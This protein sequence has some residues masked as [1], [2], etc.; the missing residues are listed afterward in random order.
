M[1]KVIH[2]AQSRDI[3]ED[4]FLSEFGCRCLTP[5]RPGN[6]VRDPV[7]LLFG[8]GF[9]RSRRVVKVAGFFVRLARVRDE[10]RGES[11]GQSAHGTNIYIV[12]SMLTILSRTFTFSGAFTYARIEF[13]RKNY[14]EIHGNQRIPKFPGMFTVFTVIFTGNHGNFYRNSR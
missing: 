8:I 4:R 12:K 6:A 13:F 7:Y 14:H 5:F 10:T 2:A 1:V 11:C 9:F 3:S